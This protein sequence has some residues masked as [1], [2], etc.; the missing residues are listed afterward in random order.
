ML[1]S[2]ALESAALA[3]SV[4]Y[5]NANRNAVNQRIYSNEIIVDTI[6]EEFPANNAFGVSDNEAIILRV[7]TA[8]SFSLSSARVTAENFEKEQN[9]LE[10]NVIHHAR[11]EEMQ[12]NASLMNLVKDVSELR[13]S[14]GD[15]DDPNASAMRSVTQLIQIIYTFAFCWKFVVNMSTCGTY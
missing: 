1:H 6:G 5:H 11:K 13:E 15:L 7:A 8:P 14:L 12:L 3:P 4:K 2:L 10:D 9:Q